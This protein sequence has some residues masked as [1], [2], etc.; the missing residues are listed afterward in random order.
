MWFICSRLGSLQRANAGPPPRETHLSALD[1]PPR[2]DLRWDP[3]HKQF[4]AVLSIQP[5]AKSY[6]EISSQT[7][8]RCKRTREGRHQ[9]C[10]EGKQEWHAQQKWHARQ[11]A[12]PLHTPEVSCNPQTCLRPVSMPDQHTEHTVSTGL[13]AGEGCGDGLIGGASDATGKVSTLYQEPVACH[14]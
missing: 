10:P 12:T 1:P 8:S 13:G 14:L 2:K 6:P 3:P 11:S 7:L 9:T 4:G 5:V